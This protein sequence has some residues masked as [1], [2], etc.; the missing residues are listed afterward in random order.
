MSLLAKPQAPVVPASVRLRQEVAVLSQ[1][2]RRV[3]DSLF[4]AW[5]TSFDLLWSEAGGV[6]PAD[7]IAAMGT[8]AAEL[9]ESSSALVQFLVDVIGDKDTEMIAQIQ[10]RVAAIPEFIAHED[11]TITL[12]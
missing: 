3:A 10:Q 9:F 7:R 8:N 2:P 5:K 12:D 6:T 11:G 4:Q 1:A